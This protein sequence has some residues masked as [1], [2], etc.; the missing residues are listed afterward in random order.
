MHACTYTYAQEIRK[1]TQKRR[2]EADE[3]G[4]GVPPLRPAQS[5]NTCIRFS[6]YDRRVNRQDSSVG[7]QALRGRLE[8]D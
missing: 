1:T 2:L 7:Q 5:V 4:H 3:G 6:Y 8:M